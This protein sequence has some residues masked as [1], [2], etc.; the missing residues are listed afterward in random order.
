MCAAY[1]SRWNS[2]AESRKSPP[3]WTTLVDSSETF[4]R[5]WGLRVWSPV[6]TMRITAR[7]VSTPKE[8]VS[9]NQF[10]ATVVSRC[11]K[12]IAWNLFLHSVTVYTLGLIQGNQQLFLQAPVTA[13]SLPWTHGVSCGCY[14][15]RVKHSFCIGPVYL[16]GKV[17]GPYFKM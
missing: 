11:T 9:S 8:V 16:I 6:I 7:A 10:R 13:W 14:T 2:R 5:R 3:F 1:G 4:R 15:S 12:L 17:K